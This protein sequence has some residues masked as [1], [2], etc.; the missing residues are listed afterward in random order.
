MASTTQDKTPLPEIP[1]DFKLEIPAVFREMFIFPTDRMSKAP[2]GAAAGWQKRIAGLKVPSS[3]TGFG[4]PA[5]KN[6]LIMVD[7]DQKEEDKDGFVHF[8]ALVDE[9][10]GGVFPE[11]YEFRTASG[12]KQLVFSCTPEIT[13]TLK[14]SQG[15]TQTGL[16]LGID[17][18]A[19]AS[20]SVGP[21]SII[22]Q[23]DGT[24]GRYEELTPGRDFAS[25]EEYPWL[26]ELLQSRAAGKTKNETYLAWK[27]K[28]AAADKA[29]SGAA[30]PS[31]TTTSTKGG[32]RKLTS[33]KGSAAVHP[34]IDSLIEAVDNGAQRHPSLFAAGSRAGK[35]GTEAVE[36]ITAAM[37]RLTALAA[38]TSGP[39]AGYDLEHAEKQLRDGWTLGNREYEDKAE[40]ETAYRFDHLADKFRADHPEYRWVLP[41]GKTD[42][43][44]WYRFDS[45]PTSKT[46]GIYAPIS[47]D[48]FAN[49][50]AAWLRADEEAAQS[51]NELERAKQAGRAIS[52]GEVWKMI[53][54][55]RGEP[56]IRATLEHFDADPRRIVDGSGIRNLDTL[57]VEP[58]TP[59]F[60]ATRKIQQRGDSE[61]YD[62]HRD[63]IE[64]IMI[65]AHPKDRPLL[66]AHLGTVLRQDQPLSKKGLILYGPTKDNGKTSLME[67]LFGVLG[68]SESDSFGLKAA[69]AALYRQS[70]NSYAEAD[71]DNRTLTVFDD[72]ASGHE[73][74]HEK[75]KQLI[76]SGQGY[77][78]RQIR[79]KTRSIRLVHTFM[80]TCNRLPNF[81]RG[82]DVIDRFEI[83]LFPYKYP[84]ADQ[85]DPSNKWHRERD[86]HFTK[87]V[88]TNPEVREAFYYYLLLRSKEWADSGSR[89][90]TSSIT[91][92]VRENKKEWMGK[93]NSLHAILTEYA[94]RS[95]EHFVSE[96]DLIALITEKLREQ[97]QG[98]L[99]QQALKTELE[100]LSL[101]KEWK[102]VRHTKK[103]RSTSKKQGLDKL[104]QSKLR[105]EDGR[106][107]S[108]PDA[109]NIYAGIRFKTDSNGDFLDEDK[110]EAFINPKPAKKP[111]VEELDADFD[112]DEAFAGFDDLL[113]QEA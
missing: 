19:K 103:K 48:D 3:A 20:Y 77:K 67:A 32:A 87:E 72:F 55:L 27:A 70:S 16:A 26:L 94:A 108:A 42:G 93:T 6:N 90:E 101:F 73:V 91:E 51:A 2:T 80:L 38:E 107:E 34:V 66:D 37:E 75:L 113:K 64:K 88:R 95:S 29:A 5:G 24:I 65:S 12:A 98:V 56:S 49:A 106:A 74:D 9:F 79:E 60:Y 61:V 99:G 76:G 43:G 111:R 22:I 71:M 50:A 36:F 11:T 68:D 8:Q 45:E 47:E 57:E 110:W 78:A 109:A 105:T 92:H 41:K 100:M 86:E 69:H 97:G 39:W 44:A 23:R 40:L 89:I 58:P 83:I 63:T 102:V 31:A 28:K 112:L 52:T 14:P 85:Y 21:G 81:G 104:V 10:G 82:E 62:R 13:E 84:S 7:L 17:I 46:Y 59:D 18:R 30:A 54:H 4:F 53:G 35:R 33:Q 25:I 96:K 15:D 1:A